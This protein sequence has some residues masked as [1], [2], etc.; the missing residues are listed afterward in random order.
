M[1]RVPV[2]RVRLRH[3]VTGGSCSEMVTRSN[4]S[5]LFLENGSCE[6]QGRRSVSLLAR[7]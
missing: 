4:A 2:G 3:R 6:V 1:L 7:G 5:E